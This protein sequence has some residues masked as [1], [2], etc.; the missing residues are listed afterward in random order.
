MRTDPDQS[1]IIATQQYV[2]AL[3]SRL[4]RNT[5]ISVLECIKVQ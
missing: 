5:D 4:T 3:G 2:S 1:C